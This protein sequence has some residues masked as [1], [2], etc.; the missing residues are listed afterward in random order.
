[1]KVWVNIFMKVSVK[2]TLKT[3]LNSQMTK[4][5]FRAKI[6]SQKEREDEEEQKFFLILPFLLGANFCMKGFFSLL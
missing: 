6:G 3:S 5:V 1:M 4:E 2:L